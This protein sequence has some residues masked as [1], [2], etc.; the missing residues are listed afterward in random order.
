MNRFE[1][2]EFRAGI[3][4]LL[5][6]REEMEEETVFSQNRNIFLNWKL[7][8]ILENKEDEIQI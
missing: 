7:V 4:R 5:S 1:L 2:L 8:E 3:D 6:Q